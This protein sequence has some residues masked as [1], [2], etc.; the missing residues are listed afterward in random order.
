MIQK[1]NLKY[2]AFLT[3]G[4]ALACSCTIFSPVQAGQIPDE[5]TRQQQ[6]EAIEPRTEHKLISIQKDSDS[7]KIIP[8]DYCESSNMQFKCFLFPEDGFTA[9][10]GDKISACRKYIYTCRN[11]PKGEVMCFRNYEF[12]ISETSPSKVFFP[13]E[14]PICTGSGIQIKD[15]DS[16]SLITSY[17]IYDGRHLEYCA[18]PP[19]SS[20]GQVYKFKDG[21][22]CTMN[23]HLYTITVP[24]GIFKDC[25]AVGACSENGSPIVGTS[26]TFYAPGVGEILNL[27]YKENKEYTAKAVLTNYQTSAKTE[28]SAFAPLS[29]NQY[30]CSPYLAEAL[31]GVTEKGTQTFN[32][33]NLETPGDF[34]QIRII[35]E[36][37]I[38]KERSGSKDASV[39]K[40]YGTDFADAE[41]E[42]IIRAYKG[43]AEPELLIPPL[44]SRDK[45]YKF[46]DK[47]Y[48]LADELFTIN[49]PVGSFKDCLQV[50]YYGK[51]SEKLQ[52]GSYRA[53]YAPSM[54]EIGREIYNP[55][56]G[57]FEKYSWLEG[58]QMA[59]KSR[60]TVNGRSSEASSKEQA[61]QKSAKEKSK[62]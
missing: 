12:C 28:Y 52:K 57:K 16:Q 6:S 14:V 26:L 5:S 9:E 38:L 20:A 4:L 18:V 7:A 21:S 2:S 60:Y 61:Q 8:E 24:A 29:I 53:Y 46:N 39:Q 13:N 25:I 17:D 35:W 36:K 27:I 54:G 23:K 33:Y 55:D 62:K 19:A 1:K 32:L 31:F 15:K 58:Y 50:I 22:C 34:D 44:D 56:S 49:T 42:S 43:T 41:S 3:A 40:V 30:M 10:N 51:E 59:P 45:P 11:L 37:N 48:K 47:Y